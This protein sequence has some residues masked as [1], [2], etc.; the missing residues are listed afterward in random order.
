MLRVTPGTVCTW[1]D[2]RFRSLVPNFSLSPF[3]SVTVPCL[4][5]RLASPG[6]GMLLRL[7]CLLA[8]VVF[9]LHSLPLPPFATISLRLALSPTVVT[10]LFQYYFQLLLEQNS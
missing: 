8:G 9:F 10:A 1:T 4:I 6:R 2:I 5:G 7:G 3:S